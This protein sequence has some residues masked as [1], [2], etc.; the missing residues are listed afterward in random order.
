VKTSSVRSARRPYNPEAPPVSGVVRLIA[1]PVAP[2][3][4][5]P[6]GQAGSVSINGDTYALT[7]IVHE[8]GDVNGYHIVKDATGSAYDLPA[9]LSTCDCPDA[10]YRV[11]PGGCRHAAALRALKAAGKIA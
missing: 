10:T 6:G 9:D 1:P 8:A 7:F 5:I 3:V 2:C 11:R 4:L